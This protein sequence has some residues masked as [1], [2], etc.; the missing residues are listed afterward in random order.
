MSTKHVHIHW[1]GEGRKYTGYSPNGIELAI[2]GDEQAGT[3]PMTLVLHAEAACSAIDVVDIL[4]KMRQTI[5]VFQVEVEA[6]RSGGDY[7]RI[8]EKI[9]LVYRLDGEIERERAERA[10]TLSLEKY[11]SVSA[12]LRPPAEIDYTI[13]INGDGPVA[14]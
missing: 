2:D 1:S 10:V 5:D 9:H 14:E 6:V 8:W 11:C 4:Q 13:I 7:P 3:S 12:M